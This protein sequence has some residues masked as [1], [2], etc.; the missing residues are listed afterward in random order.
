MCT[1][2]VVFEFPPV[3]YDNLLVI[4]TLRFVII[5]V[6]HFF[7]VLFRSIHRRTITMSFDFRCCI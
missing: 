6:V 4:L 1:L 7:V 3:T 5:V 2:V